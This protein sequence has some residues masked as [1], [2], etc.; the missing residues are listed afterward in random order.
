MHYWK[1]LGWD[2][3]L[4]AVDAL[5]GYE[6]LRVLKEDVVVVIREQNKVRKADSKLNLT[7]DSSWCLS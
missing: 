4:A 3:A 7:I 5:D 2:I 6:V 1:N